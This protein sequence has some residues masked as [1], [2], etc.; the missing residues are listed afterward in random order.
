MTF[1]AFFPSFFLKKNLQ[2]INARNIGFICNFDS[3]FVEI[4][5]IRR[6]WHDLKVN[7]SEK[8]KF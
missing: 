1:A 8:K 4:S 3:L 5:F 7:T 6:K 2:E